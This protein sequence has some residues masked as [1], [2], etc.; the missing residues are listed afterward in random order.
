MSLKS[1]GFSSGRWPGDE[2]FFDSKIRAI[3]L[4]LDK[5][6]SLIPEM[7][8]VVDE[9]DSCISR[10]YSSHQSFGESF[11]SLRPDSRA[12]LAAWIRWLPER[13]TGF[14]RLKKRIEQALWDLNSLL[15]SLDI[16]VLSI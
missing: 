11:R 16:V 10:A 6:R 7:F 2:S 9:G 8:R 5:R 13:L 3:I 14:N 15:E 4:V 1:P 12:N